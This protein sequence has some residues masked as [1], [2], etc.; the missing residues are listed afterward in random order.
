MSTTSFLLNLVPSAVSG[1]ASVPFLYAIV[2]GVG[3]RFV[4]RASLG[5]PS[6]PDLL[7]VGVVLGV[8]FLAMPKLLA[9]VGRDTVDV[10]LRLHGIITVHKGRGA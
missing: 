3:R 6:S 4:W 2:V 5:G 7:V 8:V 9:E 1:D 10:F